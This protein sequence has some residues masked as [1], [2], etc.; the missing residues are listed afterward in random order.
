[1]SDVSYT[2]VNFEDSPSTNTP[3]SADNLNVMDKGIS[4]CATE[5]NN[6]QPKTDNNLNTT[7]KT[8]TGAIN[9]INASL[10]DKA[11]I[12]DSSTTSSTETWSASKI[13]T[14][15]TD[16][17]TITNNL[18][19][20]DITSSTSVDIGV[21]IDSYRFIMTSVLGGGG[22]YQSRIIPTKLLNTTNPWQCYADANS[23]RTVTIQRGLNNHTINV[24][25]I[26]QCTL[27]G[28]YLMN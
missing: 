17:Q 22:V 24:S 3:L 18:I 25:A 23:S 19:S 16:A 21:N 11:S 6:R 1:M 14:S 20:S 5:I 13:N 2:R 27:K 9:E 4:D 15:F 8:I 26:A 12:N 7:N 28:I 10:T